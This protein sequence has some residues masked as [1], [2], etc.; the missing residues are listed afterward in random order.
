[1]WDDFDLGDL[2]IDDAVPSWAD[3]NDLGFDNARIDTTPSVFNPAKDSQAANIDGGFGPNGDFTG[4]VS[5]LPTAGVYDQLKTLVGAKTD[6]DLFRKLLGAVT[7]AGAFS[8]PGQPDWAALGGPVARTRQGQSAFQ[9]ATSPG[10]LSFGVNRRFADGGE[11]LG[12][13]EAAMPGG[14]VQGEGGGQDDTIDAR[15][16]PGEFV[17]DADT[18]AAIGDGSNEEGARRLEEFRQRIRAHKRSAPHDE[19]PPQTGPLE[20]Y[21]M[22]EK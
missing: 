3:F 6:A 21:A 15:L 1:M 8:K 13:L 12:A 2:N 20:Q 10:G 11:V 18:V 9:M 19:I 16:S 17:F 14:Y 7:A 5:G 4:G 22:G